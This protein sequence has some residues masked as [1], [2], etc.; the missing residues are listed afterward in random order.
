MSD[1][2]VII[3]SRLHGMAIL[4]C[5]GTVSLIPLT[6]LRYSVKRQVMSHNLETWALRHGQRVQVA[7]S[8]SL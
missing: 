6:M 3:Y 8:V 4:L 1:M 2:I 7:A 5:P